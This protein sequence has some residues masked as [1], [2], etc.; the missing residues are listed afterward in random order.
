M[1]NSLTA[2]LTM[3]PTAA[4]AEA[5]ARSMLTVEAWNAR[6]AWGRHEDVL[7]EN[8]PEGGVSAPGTAI[9]TAGPGEE[10]A[11]RF[12]WDRSRRRGGGSVRCRAI[13]RWPVPPRW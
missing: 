6:L 7:A 13:P 10:F 11:D 9:F 8:C 1:A 5:V 2:A 12:G 3:S 4:A